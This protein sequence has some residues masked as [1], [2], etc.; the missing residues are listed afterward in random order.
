MPGSWINVGGHG[1]VMN[2]ERIPDER[3]G[4]RRAQSPSLST[5]VQ[6]TAKETGYDP[7]VVQTVAEHFIRSLSETDRTGPL[8]LR[9]GAGCVHT[10]PKPQSGSDERRAPGALI[11]ALVEAQFRDTDHEA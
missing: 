10:G 5:W 7:G 6:S 2:V 3:G 9:P 11:R 8:G 1:K 4:L